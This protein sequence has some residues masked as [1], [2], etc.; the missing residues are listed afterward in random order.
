VA[1]GLEIG[2]QSGMSRVDPEIRG[3]VNFVRHG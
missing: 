1:A 2:I 3:L